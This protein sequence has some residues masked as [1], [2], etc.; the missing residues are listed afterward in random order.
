MEENYLLINAF[1]TEQGRTRG[2]WGR[3]SPVNPRLGKRKGKIALKMHE[4][5]SYLKNSPPAA[6]NANRHRR[7]HSFSI[8]K[9]KFS[10]F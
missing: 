10:N 6:C 4:N 2:D 1:K 9:A 3:M 8:I 5:V 7:H